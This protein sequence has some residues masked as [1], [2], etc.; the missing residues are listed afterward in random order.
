MTHFLLVR[1]YAIWNHIGPREIKIGKL[2]G[3]PV[4]LDVLDCSAVQPAYEYANILRFFCVHEMKFSAE[5][6]FKLSLLEKATYLAYVIILTIILLR[7]YSLNYQI[8]IN[9]Y[10]I[11]IIAQSDVIFCLI[12]LDF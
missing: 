11:K 7:F 6:A 10:I 4:K 5:D 3:S 2:E 1:I 9:A 8:G 12:F